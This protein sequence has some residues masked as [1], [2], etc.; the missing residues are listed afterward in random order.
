MRQ[1]AAWALASIG[2]AGATDALLK[3][4][5]QAEGWDRTEATRHCLLL[6]ERLVAT[7]QNPPAARIYTHLRDTR[8]NPGERH[9]RAAA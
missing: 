3:S 1:T 4:A 2:D 8:N 9:V 5:D 7:G 6:A